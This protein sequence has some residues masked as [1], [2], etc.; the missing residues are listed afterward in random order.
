[1]E[2]P[3]PQFN[4]PVEKNRSL[5]DTGQE[6]NRDWDFI[7]AGHGETFPGM[8]A[9]PPARFKVNRAH[10]HGSSGRFRGPGDLSLEPLEGNI[11]NGPS[12]KRSGNRSQA[13]PRKTE[14]QEQPEKPEKG[15]RGPERGLK[16]KHAFYPGVHVFELGE[17][18]ARVSG[19]FPPEGKKIK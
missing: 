9:D 3:G 10:P 16:G 13:G 12:G 11:G 14:E 2:I 8:K 15:L 5:I 6:L 4:H 17:R 19:I 7:R 18:I 1:M